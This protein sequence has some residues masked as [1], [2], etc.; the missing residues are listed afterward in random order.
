MSYFHV[1]LILAARGNNGEEGGWVQLLIFMVIA[2]F[3]AVG[4]IAKAR[5]NKV[6]QG[7]FPEE[8]PE[9]GPEEDGRPRPAPQPRIQRPMQNTAAYQQMAIEHLRE[10]TPR[11]NIRTEELRAQKAAPEVSLTDSRELAELSGIGENEP[12]RIVS[13]KAESKGTIKRLLRFEESS[14]LR[15]AILHYE[16][17]GKPLSLRDPSEKGSFD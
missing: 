1:E 10:S 16:I 5:A 4:G 6:T 8:E 11:R 15:K 17:L 13:K 3:W 12:H 7:D 9:E 14:D 2:V